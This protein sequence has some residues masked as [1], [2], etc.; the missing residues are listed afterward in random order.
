MMWF[1]RF[2]TYNIAFVLMGILYAQP[3]EVDTQNDF[4]L[5]KIVVSGTG[6]DLPLRDE[7][8]NIF[9]IDKKDLH[10]KGYKDLQQALQ[11]SPFVG[12]TD[13][14]FGSNIDLRGQGVDANRA[15]KLLVNRVPINFLDTLYGIPLINAVNIEDI[16]SIEVIPGGGAVIY[17][18]GTRGGVINIVTKAPNNDYF[19]FMIKGSSAEASGVQTSNI[20]ISKGHRLNEHLFLRLDLAGG[21][22]GATR[23]GKN[24]DK[25]NSKNTYGAFEVSYEINE[26][27]KLDFN[28]IYAHS[29]EDRPINDLF[30]SV[31][32]TGIRKSLE[33]K[34]KERYEAGT[35]TKQDQLDTFQ[36]SLNYTANLANAYSFDVLAF[37]KFNRLFYTQYKYYFL[38][39]DKRFTHSL[40]NN[41]A[42]F[43][44]Q[45][46]GLNLKVKHGVEKNM[47][48]VGLD[49]SLENSNC[50]SGIHA[51]SSLLVF[52]DLYQEIKSLNT[53]TKL[54]NSLYV[55]DVIKPISKFE[56]GIGGRVE[57]S[58]YWT[59]SDQ[60]TKTFPIA[61]I[62]EDLNFKDKNALVS[63]AAQIIPNF[64]YSNTGNAYA[65]VE[66]GFISPSPSQMIKTDSN[67]FINQYR[68]KNR[69]FFIYANEN[70]HILPEQYLTAELGWKDEF[71]YSFVSASLFYT[72]T[73]DEIFLNLLPADN[74]IFSDVFGT[75]SDTFYT[76]GNLGET[77]RAGLELLA[78]Q[79]ILNDD[80]LRLS[81]G[82]S[83]L[84]TNILQ[85]NNSNQH[86]KSKQL[87]YVP[88]VKL[89]LLI[90][91]DV[92][93]NSSSFL[94]LFLNNVYYSQN[95]DSSGNLMN[96]GGYFLNDLGLSYG[97]R[98]FKVNLGI[99]NIFD[100][101]YETYQ[102]PDNDQ[103]KWAIGRNYYAE[104]RYEF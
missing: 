38:V 98:A 89:T 31:R 79:R 56:V 28:L 45:G 100:S 46:G 72:H 23:N 55:Y 104:F 11:Y 32:G 57:L 96:K 75:G 7:A 77:Q 34:K 51:I 19:R 61:T 67:S 5:S 85:S 93:K 64:K 83:Y 26:N 78:M 84:Y 94:T 48:Y 18:N 15:V 49:N 62:S 17:G 99:R 16:K 36:T 10:N 1:Y 102:K 69:K 43:F 12:F 76:Y 74:I 21:Y 13:N 91:G 52:G 33:Q 29:W 24:F 40:D 42:G 60:H 50:I 4:I 87:P 41:G 59:T 66:L 70:T 44:N 65:L 37:Y 27:Q 30:L 6:F 73:F 35:D 92:Y 63:Y 95:I 71:V 88:S 14:G 58:N 9:V 81:E 90:E 22:D 3:T 39:F 97:V 53:A 47:L 20:N 2:V 86:L 103:Y 82:I 25:D 8:K 80:A 101:F 54:S 68:L